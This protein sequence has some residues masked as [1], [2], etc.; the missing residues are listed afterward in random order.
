MKK[1]LFTLSLILLVIYGSFAQKGKFQVKKAKYKVGEPYKVVDAS[2]KFYSTRDGEMISVK[3]RKAMVSVQKFDS[4]KLTETS[5]NI[6]KKMVKGF[7]LEGFVEF[8]NKYYLFYSVWDRP[9]KTEQLFYR[10]V[11]F[12]NASISE[13]EV[14]V[15][16]VD[17]Y[18]RG[19]FIESGAGGVGGVRGKFDF[20]SSYDKK[21]LMVV[22]R[23][24]PEEKKDALSYDIIGMFVFD[25]N[26]KEIGGDEIKMPYTEAKMDN[27]GYSVDKKGNIYILARVYIGDSKRDRERGSNEAN[28]RIE[29]L[30][31]PEGTKNVRKND[32]DKTVLKLGDLFIQDIVLYE[33]PNDYMTC[34]GYYTQGKNID[35]A[36]GVFTFKIGPEGDLYDRA[37]HE[38]PLELLNQYKSVRAQEK[39][40]KKTENKII[41]LPSLTLRNFK[42]MEDGSIILVG[43]QYWKE[44]YRTTNANGSTTTTTYYYYYDMVFTKISPTGEIDFMKYLPKRQTGT[45]TGQGGMS[46]KYMYDQERKTH[47]LVFLDNVKNMNLDA[48]KTPATHR[49][50]A[51]GF[52]T[53]YAI[54]NEEGEVSKVSILDIKD[55]QGIS[56]KQFS[57]GRI[58]GLGSGEFLFEAYKK[59]KE[60]ILVKVTLKE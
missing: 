22:Y 37:E 26:M 49:D 10:E 13:E 29:V 28:Y 2:Y 47:Y 27:I 6:V 15:L 7:E 5:V 38:F 20:Y 53:A 14:P 52:L 24:K 17:G 25:E 16:K 56:I 36:T 3:V 42:I 60:D 48:N 43:E 19:T 59:K 35:G 41:A 33:G 58:I 51:G 39:T 31:V 8:A 1:A 55:A 9:N 23:K 54:E 18:I 44:V 21:K 11:D 50:G 34:M 46:F 40:K 57:V 12:E 32:I 30:R 4:K 45:N